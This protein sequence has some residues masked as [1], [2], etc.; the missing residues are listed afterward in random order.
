M[1]GRNRIS[2]TNSV[3]VFL[4]LLFC[5][6]CAKPVVYRPKPLTAPEIVHCLE[7]MGYLPG[8]KPFILG[9]GGSYDYSNPTPERVHVWQQE[10]YFSGMTYKEVR[11]LYASKGYKTVFDQPLCEGK[12]PALG[13][14]CLVPPAP[15]TEEYERI[16][17]GGNTQ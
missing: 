2:Y 8:C 1:I 6:G 17:S 15:G 3:T 5:L 13:G 14:N 16:V 4:I 7:P 10:G 11:D 9:G 12:H